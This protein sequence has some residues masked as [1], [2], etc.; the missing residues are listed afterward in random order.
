MKPIEELLKPIE[1]LLCYLRRDVK[2]WCEGYRLR[3]SASKGGPTMAL[4]VQLQECKAETFEFLNKDILALHSTFESIRPIPRDAELPLS[5]AQQRLWF[6]DQLEPASAA[7][8]MPTAV[9]LTGA[10]DIAVLERSLNEIVRRHDVLRTTFPMVNGVPV[11]V[12]ASELTS[13]SS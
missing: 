11:Q 9:Y 10:L 7:Y 13:A 1:E 5:Y 2:L 3:Y 8:N 6:L 12:I 4:R